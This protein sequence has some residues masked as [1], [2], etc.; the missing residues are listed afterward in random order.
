MSSLQ[1]MQISFSPEHD[2]LLLRIKSSDNSEF[3]LWLTRRFVAM[4][5]PS[6]VGLLVSNP[7]VTSQ[8]SREAQ[9]AVLEFEHENAVNQADFDQPYEEKIEA[10][11][12]GK[13]PMLVSQM[14][15]QRSK[16][17]K[18]T[19]IF[20]PAKGQGV[21]LNMGND[22]IHSFCKLLSDAVDKT[23][24]NLEL[25]IVNQSMAEAQGA[26]LQ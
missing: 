6:L 4:A 8:P 25:Q 5:W 10:L 23:D 18:H 17:D 22:L 13:E 3:R 14:S 9:Q 11:P 20:K 15:I 16:D 26:T 24:W 1:Q 7:A 19:V 12:L 2:R 21:N